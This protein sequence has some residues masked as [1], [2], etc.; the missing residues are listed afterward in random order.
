MA[1]LSEIIAALGL[2]AALRIPLVPSA[3]LSLLP[4]VFVIGT[5]PSVGPSPR[6]VRMYFYPAASLICPKVPRPSVQA[7]RCAASSSCGWNDDLPPVRI[8][9]APPICCAIAALTAAVDALAGVFLGHRR[10]SIIDPFGHQ[11][12]LSGTAATS[13]FQR[14]DLHYPERATSASEGHAFATASDTEVSCRYES[15]GRRSSRS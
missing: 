5:I 7:R 2:T 13:Y 6:S 11:P 12:M 1:R 9:V 15:G 10:L 14:R 8:C 4:S 3:W